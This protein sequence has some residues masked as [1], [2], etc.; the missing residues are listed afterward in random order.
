MRINNRLISPGIPNTEQTQ[1]ENR[2]ALITPEK[3]GK[4]FINVSP[5]TPLKADEIILFKDFAFARV[6][7][8]EIAAQ[9]ITM[10]I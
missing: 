6:N 10:T 9:H 5:K 7:I 1:I 8:S 3:N 4:L 2:L